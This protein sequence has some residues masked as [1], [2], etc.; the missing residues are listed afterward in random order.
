VIVVKI[1]QALDRYSFLKRSGNPSKHRLEPP[2]LLEPGSSFH[3]SLLCLAEVKASF[4]NA[5]ETL[6]KS[7]GASFLQVI[8]LSE[9]A[10]DNHPVFRSLAVL[11]NTKDL[12]HLRNS[13]DSIPF[14]FL[15]YL[16][17]SNRLLFIKM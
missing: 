9:L 16:S 3:S 1:Y 12:Y 4:Q 2:V 8:C 14:H 15:S 11:N 13:V 17:S 10:L 6:F 5:K 7:L